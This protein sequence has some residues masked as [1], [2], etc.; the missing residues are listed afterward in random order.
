MGPVLMLLHVTIIFDGNLR[1]MK[2]FPG[3]ISVIRRF[4]SQCDTS[5]TYSTNTLAR[6]NTILNNKNFLK[7][8][9]VSVD[10]HC[11][12]RTDHNYY[13]VSAC[14]NLISFACNVLS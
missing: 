12:C 4:S 3:I 14:S 5:S 6:E 9:E 8:F 2:L 11:C 10:L 13:T 7:Q 1:L